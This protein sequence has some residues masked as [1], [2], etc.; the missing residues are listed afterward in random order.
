MTVPN[1]TP[2]NSLRVIHASTLYIVVHPRECLRRS[3]DDPAGGAAGPC[4]GPHGAAAT[5]HRHPRTGRASGGG[6]PLFVGPHII[7]VPE[8]EGSL[9][10]FSKCLY[11][12]SSVQPKTTPGPTPIFL[13]RGIEVLQRMPSYYGEWVSLTHSIMVIF[14]RVSILFFHTAYLVQIRKD[15]VQGFQILGGGGF[16][17][18]FEKENENTNKEGVASNPHPPF[19]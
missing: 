1:I 19:I 8:T 7:P 9:E 11:A 10:P 5:D 4:R 15:Q 2:S 13:L 16:G 12:T 6:R 3:S 17:A 14:C 18:G